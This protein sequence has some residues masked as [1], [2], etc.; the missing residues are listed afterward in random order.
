MPYACSK[1]HT[2]T[3]PF[4]P[5][6]VSYVVDVVMGLTVHPFAA[7]PR[8][9]SISASVDLYLEPRVHQQSGLGAG[10]CTPSGPWRLHGREDQRVSRP[11]AFKEGV[12][13]TI[14]RFCVGILPGKPGSPYHQGCPTSG[15]QT[16][17]DEVS[18]RP[19]D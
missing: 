19:T 18:C 17:H 1:M 3:L 15:L 7:L 16:S 4:N 8:S 10:Q 9:V 6:A 14:H 2:L 11:E 5:N 13:E 12:L